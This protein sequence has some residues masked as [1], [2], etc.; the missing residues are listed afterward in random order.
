MRRATVSGGSL[1]CRA[2]GRCGG[3][4]L[5]AALA[6]VAV[7]G[8]ASA[9]PDTPTDTQLEDAR[10]AAD[11]VAAQ[12]AQVLT[13]LGDARAA[14]TAAATDA[15]AARDR[16]DQEL[17]DWSAAQAVADT[18]QATA[19]RSAQDLGGARADLVA[20]ARTSYLDGG[21]APGLRA[22]LTSADP[23]QLLE[24]AALLEAVGQHR[25]DVLGRFT[26]VEQQAAEAS[27]AAG[28][29]L[30]AA[31]TLEDQAAAQLQ[32]AEQREADA[33]QRAADFATQQVTLESQVEQARATFVALQTQRT[34]ADRQAA[35]QEAAAQ[36]VA[37]QQE[38]ARRAAARETAARQA[39][40]VPTVAPRAAP[41]SPVAAP[42]TAPPDPVAPTV[43]PPV[44]A[45]HDWTSV[46]ACES[47][48]NWSTNTGNGYYGGLQFSLST[49][50]AFG[51]TAFAA[52][53][54]LATPGQQVAVAE[55]VLAEQGPGAWP[56]C[57]RLLT[58]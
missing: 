33:R 22:L 27:A 9:Q 21:T 1:R 29:A 43:G 12:V 58:S 13:E 24:R 8:T 49:W 35:Q 39:A 31:V 37:A 45:A 46:A 50:A 57:G 6:L 15:A 56:T 38:A 18:A 2:A 41:R 54:D 10:Q 51:G 40:A 42:S 36:A 14:V 16:H 44:R 23:A 34:A 20:F 7:P 17:A 52:R 5:A 30:A 55:A 48:G 4:A 32:V 53:A 28:A 25:S 47:G 3:I 26:V 19:R 11:D